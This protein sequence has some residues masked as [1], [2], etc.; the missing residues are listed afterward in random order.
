MDFIRAYQEYLDTIKCKWLLVK[1]DVW[2]KE[3]FKPSPDFI[4]K[5]NNVPQQ[6]DPVNEPLEALLNIID[7]LGKSH[8]SNNEVIHLG[9]KIITLKNWFI[10]NANNHEKV[11]LFIRDISSMPEKIIFEITVVLRQVYD[12]LPDTIKNEP[13]LSIVILD[14][15]SRLFLATALISGYA[16]LCY[17]YRLPFLSVDDIRLLIQENFKK[18]IDSDS[19]EKESTNKDIVSD[20]AIK[21]IYK[22]TGGQL[23][24]VQELLRRLKPDNDFKIN[25]KEL[26]RLFKYL[27]TSPPTVVKRW[28][29]D[30][31]AIL[32]ADKSLI[33]S[34]QAYAKGFGLSKERQPPP[35]KEL[36]LFL[37]GWLKLDNEGYWGISSR[38]HA[39][40]ALSVLNELAREMENKSSKASLALSVFEALDKESKHGKD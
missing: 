33:T 8:D 28:Q 24:L 25:N 35:I 3:A 23:L 40:L 9:D 5:S 26:S 11:V 31:K 38:I 19:S 1:A 17:Q 7:I 18:L 20:D 14:N 37:S 10:D 22:L 32:Q 36:H 34:M 15:N 16:D 27:R 13:K 29:A 30:L 2:C 4:I 6:N 12:L 21:E 39:S